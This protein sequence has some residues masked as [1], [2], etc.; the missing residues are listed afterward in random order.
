[1]G[2][3]SR[4][5]SCSSCASAKRTLPCQDHHL[6]TSV[7]DVGGAL[8]SAFVG[9]VRRP[10]SCVGS[11]VGLVAHRPLVRIHVLDMCTTGESARAFRT[12]VSARFG[13]K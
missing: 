11:M 4:S 2:A 13:A 10:R 5:A 7:E 3:A 8:Q 9:H 1:M 6:L 12:K